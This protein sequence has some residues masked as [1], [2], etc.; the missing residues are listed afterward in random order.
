MATNM[1]VRFD[2]IEGE[3][4]YKEKRSQKNWCEFFL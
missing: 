4:E 1:F 2:T 3:G